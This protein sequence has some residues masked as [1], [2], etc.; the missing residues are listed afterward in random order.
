MSAEE[1]RRM[2]IDYWY[3][4]VLS[5]SSFSIDDIAKIMIEFSEEYDKFD[6]KIVDF[7][8]KHGTLDLEN[9]DQTISHYNV[10]NDWES[11]S[12]TGYGIVE[13]IAGRK[14]HWKLQIIDKTIDANIGIIDAK[15][16]N[17]K[18]GKDITECI[19]WE[20]DDGFSYYSITGDLWHE[21]EVNTYGVGL[22]KDDI[23]EIWLDLKENNELRYT[24]NDKDYGTAAKVKSDITYKLAVGLWTGKITLLSFDTI[25]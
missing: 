9:D 15:L 3:R 16:Q 13:A 17:G 12:M 6:A 24:V 8:V 2:I 7:N 23:I 25:Y 18:T 21:N 20:E 22:D 5:S 4:K 1:T 19:W 10:G 14:Y 11:Y